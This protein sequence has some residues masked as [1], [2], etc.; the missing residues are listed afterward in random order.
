MPRRPL[1]AIKVPSRPPKQIE[2]VINHILHGVLDSAERDTSHGFTLNE[3]RFILWAMSQHGQPTRQRRVPPNISSLPR[4]LY[5]TAPPEWATM[6]QSD[7]AA[8]PLRQSK[9]Q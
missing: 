9:V 5:N 1:K 8:R 3:K 4:D 6:R 7:N 2:E